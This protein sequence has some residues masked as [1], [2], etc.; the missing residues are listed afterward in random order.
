M[1]PGPRASA[2]RARAAPSP[3]RV[4]SRAPVGAVLAATLRGFVLGV[5]PG[6]PLA[7]QR[8][9]VPVTTPNGP[10]RAGVGPAHLGRWRAGPQRPASAKQPVRKKTKSR[11]SPLPGPSPLTALPPGG[12]QEPSRVRKV[13]FAARG[14]GKAGMVCSSRV[15]RY[16]QAAWDASSQAHLA[17][18]AATR[19]APPQASGTV[20]GRRRASARAAEL[21]ARAA[22]RRSARGGRQASAGRGPG[23]LA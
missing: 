23:R 3:G 19:R 2:A 16:S 21:R 12:W 8:K 10:R 14:A 18:P 4:S 6:P 20:K 11:Q 1:A 7:C 15:A 17:S 5:V 13:V 9:L 22:S